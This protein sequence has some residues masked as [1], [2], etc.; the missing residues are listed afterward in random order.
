MKMILRITISIL[1][2]GFFSCNTQQEDAQQTKMEIVDRVLYPKTNLSPLL[3][4]IR[5]AKQTFTIKGEK[6][7]L[8]VGLNGMTLTIL[9]NTFVNREGQVAGTVTI[10]VVEINSVSDIINAN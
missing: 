7:T 8:I 5:P 2:F 3:D 4:S 10:D 1:A 6:D 9:K